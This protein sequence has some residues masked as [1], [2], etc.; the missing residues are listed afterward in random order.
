M[1]AP[2]SSSKTNKI[3][4]KLVSVVVSLILLHSIKMTSLHP[5]ISALLV[6]QPLF[7]RFFHSRL[8]ESTFYNI[9][10]YPVLNIAA[11]VLVIR[12]HT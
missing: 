7:A 11:C 2:S 3:M 6:R 10:Y 8:H 5:T 9:T 1:A 12:I 4:V